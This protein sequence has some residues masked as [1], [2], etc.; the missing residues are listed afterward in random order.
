MAIPSDCPDCGDMDLDVASIPPQ[1]HDRG[2][3]WVTR[4]TD[5]SCSHIAWFE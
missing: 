3:S 4:T 5:T 2:D 1:N